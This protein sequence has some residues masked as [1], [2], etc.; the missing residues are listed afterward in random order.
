LKSFEAF[1]A[2]F[3][4]NKNLFEVNDEI[5][6][7]FFD[8]FTEFS[9]QEKQNIYNKKHENN[10]I[11]QCELQE[12]LD[13][14]NNMI[15]KIICVLDNRLLSLDPFLLISFI[16]SLWKINYYSNNKIWIKLEYILVRTNLLRNISMDFYYIVLKAFE[17]FFNREDSTILPDEIFEVV[18]YNSILT[19]KDAEGQKLFKKVNE[20]LIVFDKNFNYS[21]DKYKKEGLIF[22]LINTS[23]NRKISFLNANNIKN[24]N[25]NIFIMRNC[26]E[27]DDSPFQEFS[28]IESFH[29]KYFFNLCETFCCFAKNLE[30][31]QDFY[32]FFIELIFTADN[33]Q[34]FYNI[35]IFIFLYD[36]NPQNNHESNCQFKIMN[37]KLFECL[38]NLYFSTI[39]IQE[40]VYNKNYLKEFLK[41]IESIVL[42]IFSNLAVNLNRLHF[43][44]TIFSVNSQPN[45]IYLNID[46]KNY[47]LNNC[48][49]DREQNKF[50]LFRHD[51]FQIFNMITDEMRDILLWCFCKRKLLEQNKYLIDIL[52]I[53]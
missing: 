50:L 6:L 37:N 36:S 18:E 51:E 46:H 8:Y 23:K 21:L 44:K 38:V 7:L 13:K 24:P 31:S 49:F 34:I 28:E 42:E 45:L 25:Q 47:I 3:T 52:S 15:E 40:N 48:S 16:E 4:G 2:Y 10:Q 27:E 22:P 12:V 26:K 11:I 14:I 29:L 5:T 20:K 43:D 17:G 41:E 35:F 9:A 1:E 39:L 53:N 33:I 32:K 19:F 30:G